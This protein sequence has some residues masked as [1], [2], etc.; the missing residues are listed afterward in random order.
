M[1]T[2]L[3]CASMHTFVNCSFEAA[4]SGT[5]T[6]HLGSIKTTKKCSDVSH[7]AD[8]FLRGL[9][10]VLFLPFK[11]NLSHVIRVKLTALNNNLICSLTGENS[12][13][14]H[15]TIFL[16]HI[17]GYTETCS[18]PRFNKFWRRSAELPVVVSYFKWEL[19]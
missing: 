16:T 15:R 18:C 9:V 7:K 5:V 19:S 17:L 13:D 12:R 8:S 14:S 6:K 11:L 3:N 4:H 1:Q 10:L 2:G